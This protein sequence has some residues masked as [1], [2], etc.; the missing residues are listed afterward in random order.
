MRQSLA[1]FALP[2]RS[3][4]AVLGKGRDE[5]RDLVIRS[6][7]CTDKDDPVLLFPAMKA[8]VSRAPSHPLSAYPG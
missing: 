3:Y 1:K 4:I 5:V 6:V 8:S 7:G 2:A